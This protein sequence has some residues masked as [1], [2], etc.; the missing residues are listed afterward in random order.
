MNNVVSAEA[1]A[2]QAG[3]PVLVMGPPGTG[4]TALTLGIGKKL[5]RYT[6]VFIGSIHEPGDLGFPSPEDGQLGYLTPKFVNKLNEKPSILFFDEFTTCTPMM[7]N[8]LLRVVCE[9]WVGDT[10]LK[11]FVSIVAAGNPSEYNAGA[12]EL[13]MPMANRFCHLTWEF[14]YEEWTIAAVA[15]WP[16]PSFPIVPKNWQ[17]GKSASMARIAAFGK[18]RPAM[19]LQLPKEEISKSG[20]WASPRSWEMGATLEAACTAARVGNEIKMMLLAGCVGTGPALE[21]FAWCKDQDL[22]DPEIFIRDPLKFTLPERQDIQFAVLASVAAAVMAR[23]TDE[24]YLNAWK[25]LERA[26]NQ[27]GLDVAVVAARSLLSI[28][29]EDLPLPLEE[30]KPFERILKKA[31]V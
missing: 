15:G 14:N 5:D 6:H 2:I 25:V 18:H 24:R 22:P 19:L 7:Q 3:V 23:L 28:D 11:E 20:A 29:K 31:G 12:Y 17:V 9:R 13:S 21:Y 8:G 1:I 30:L 16:E 10:Q 27:G 4:K 26:A